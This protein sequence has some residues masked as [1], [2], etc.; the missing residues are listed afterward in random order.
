MGT[1]AFAAPLLPGKTDAW[2]QWAAELH[3]PR[4]ADFAE[5]NSRHGLTRHAAWLQQTPMGDIAAVLI[6]GEGAEQF[7][8]SVAA[9][10][11]EFDA[12]FRDNVSDLHGIDFSNPPPLPEAVI[13]ARA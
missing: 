12:W 4:S 13:D 5:F 1:V 3:G 11:H 9:G 2:R 10:D 8:G 6:E 7:M